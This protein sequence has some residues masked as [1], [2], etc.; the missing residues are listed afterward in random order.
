M[1]SPTI[2]SRLLVTLGDTRS[3]HLLTLGCNM[4]RLLLSL[5]VTRSRRL[6]IQ[7]LSTLWSPSLFFWFQPYRLHKQYP[8]CGPQDYYSGSSLIDLVSNFIFLAPSLIHLL[9]PKPMPLAPV[10]SSTLF[11]IALLATWFLNSP[12][13]I[14]GARGTGMNLYLN[15][16]AAC[17]ACYN[18]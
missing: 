10:L 18:Q 1:V 8:P 2:S 16:V 17:L 9:V 4:L 3:R 14:Q 6:V 15:L 13:L 12:P 11:S 7:A 5:S